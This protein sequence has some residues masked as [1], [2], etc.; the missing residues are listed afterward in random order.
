VSAIVNG[1]HVH[2]R[3]TSRLNG[4]EPLGDEKADGPKHFDCG[5]VARTTASSKY[6]TCRVWRLFDA[7]QC[8]TDDKSDW[9]TWHRHQSKICSSNIRPFVNFMLELHNIRT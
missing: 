5:L 4:F 9:L 6:V 8:W 2:E 7:G 1:P 3:Q